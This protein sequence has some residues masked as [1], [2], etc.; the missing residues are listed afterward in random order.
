MLLAI[1]AHLHVE[2]GIAVIMTGRNLVLDCVVNTGTY[3]R[4][5]L[6]IDEIVARCASL[7][8]SKLVIAHTHPTETGS[9]PSDMD[10]EWAADMLAIFGRAGISVVDNLVVC[11]VGGTTDL[12]SVHNTL[13]FKQMVREY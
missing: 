11:S 8:A 2:A 5:T 10:I 12:K 7:G 3:N 1:D 9:R 13:R 4:I 6:P